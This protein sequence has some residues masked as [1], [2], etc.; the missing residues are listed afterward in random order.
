ML[1]DRCFEIDKG[2][3]R[4]VVSSEHMPSIPRSHLS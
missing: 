3:N 2:T 1:F 4:L